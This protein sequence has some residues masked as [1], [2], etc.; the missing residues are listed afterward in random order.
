M[1]GA[2]LWCYTQYI[3]QLHNITLNKSVVKKE[4][5]NLYGYSRTDSIPDIMCISYIILIGPRTITRQFLP[6]ELRF[7]R[8]L[9][10]IKTVTSDMIYI[11]PA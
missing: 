4:V 11:Q 2:P 3:I 10:T 8:P 9:H 7:S 6:V 5:E 1:E